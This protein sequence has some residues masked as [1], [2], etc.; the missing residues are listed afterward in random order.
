MKCLA[1]CGSDSACASNCTRDQVACSNACPCGAD[2]P[3]GCDGMCSNPFCKSVMVLHTY[4][5][6]VPRTPPVKVDYLGHE[7]RDFNFEMNEV[8]VRMSCMT[9]YNGEHFIF[10]GDVGDPAT[11]DAT[12]FIYQMA[13][14][15]GCGL[16]K[17]PDLPF[18]FTQVGE[19]VARISHT[20]WPIRLILDV[21][22]FVSISLLIKCI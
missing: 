2:C 10:G 15:D 6:P 9:E 7:Y 1:D 17:L 20:V 12:G 19:T 5:Y 11:G 21:I 14:I 22:I 3:E 13:K 4:D 8:A 16:K 18:S